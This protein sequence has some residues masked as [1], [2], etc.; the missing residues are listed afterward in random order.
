TDAVDHHEIVAESV[1][2]G[3]IQFHNGRFYQR[4]ERFSGGK[5]TTLLTTDRIF[6][7]G[8]SRPCEMRATFSSIIRIKSWKTTSTKRGDQQDRIEPEHCPNQYLKHVQAG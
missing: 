3:E 8:S 4:F 7:D 1:H 2:L 5:Q 6:P